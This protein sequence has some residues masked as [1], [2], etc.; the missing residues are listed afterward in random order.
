MNSLRIHVNTLCVLHTKQGVCDMAYQNMVAERCAIQ[1]LVHGCDDPQTLNPVQALAV[2]ISL[3]RIVPL[4]IFFIRDKFAGT[5]RAK[6]ACTQTHTHTR[7][8]AH[9]PY[10]SFIRTRFRY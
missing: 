10:P 6:C 5:E 7:T 3:L 1:Y 9:C 8:R 2:G 4:V